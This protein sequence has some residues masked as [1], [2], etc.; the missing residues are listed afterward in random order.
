MIM[1]STINDIDSLGALAQSCY[2][3][4]YIYIYAHKDTII[5]AKPQRQSR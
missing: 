5:M 2:I 3:Y 4:V 1:I